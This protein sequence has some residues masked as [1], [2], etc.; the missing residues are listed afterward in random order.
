MSTSTITGYHAHVY[1]DEA[2]AEQA[3][4]LRE[5][6]NEKFDYK[7]GRFHEKNVGPHSRWSFQIAFEPEGLGT[8]VPWLVINRKGLTVFV[9]GLSGDDIYDHT[10]LVMWLGESV[11]LDLDA[12]SGPQASHAQTHQKNEELVKR[13]HEEGINQQN[14]E[15][16]LELCAESFQFHSALVTPDYPTGAASLR[17]WAKA[18]FEFFPDFHVILQDMVS[19]DDKVAFRVGITATH[20]GEIFGVAPT[21]NL[22]SWDGMGMFRIENGR[23][24]EFWWMPDLF[25]LM[26]Q[27]GLVPE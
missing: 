15:L 22:L 27:L 26:R 20:G 11:E 8:F 6:I 17:H 2:T 9:H 4:T 3:H 13:W 1:F 16:A 7:V 18:T 24:A 19:E 25:T 21:G 14:A 23:L 5:Q 12:L 10:E